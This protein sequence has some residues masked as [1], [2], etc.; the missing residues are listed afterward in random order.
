MDLEWSPSLPGRIIP[1]I[2]EPCFHYISLWLEPRA[3]ID[4]VV[5]TYVRHYRESNPGIQLL[6]LLLFTQ[7]TDNLAVNLI[8]S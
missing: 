8:L 2:E 4:V 6:Y 1:L 3:D 5:K 7:S